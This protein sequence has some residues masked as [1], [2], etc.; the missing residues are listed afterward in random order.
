MS[1]GKAI[2]VAESLLQ[3]GYDVEI[4]R[5]GSDSAQVFALR[6]KKIKRPDDESDR[7]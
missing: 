7:N 3:E 6:K 4:R 2:V 1:F 5:I